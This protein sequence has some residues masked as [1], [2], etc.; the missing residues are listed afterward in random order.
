MQKIKDL[1]EELKKSA[2]IRM[3]VPS[4]QVEA[5]IERIISLPEHEREKALEVVRKAEEAFAQ[6]AK[7]EEK[8][9]KN[10]LQKIDKFKAKTRE[11]YQKEGQSLKESKTL[12]QK[13]KSKW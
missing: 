7:S 3:K 9:S 4:D 5:F 6:F 13:L 1:T 8:N 2:F 12:I 11:K 10:L